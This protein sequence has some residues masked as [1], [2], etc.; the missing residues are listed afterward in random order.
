VGD[1]ADYLID[2]MCFGPWFFED[3]DDMYDRVEEEREQRIA[4]LAL[5]YHT[6]RDGRRSKIRYMEER[7][8]RNAIAWGKK[9]K[10][11]LE[12]WDLAVPAFEG[13]L[14]RRGKPV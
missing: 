2:R 12:F 10:H 5:G 6:T 11:N 14:K 8:L 1:E 9:T 7:H 4:D 13:E 3:G